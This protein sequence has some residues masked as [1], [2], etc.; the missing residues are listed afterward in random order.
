MSFFP[1]TSS[2]LK[3][4]ITSEPSGC[5]AAPDVMES[6][7]ELYKVSID[8]VLKKAQGQETATQWRL[9]EAG[10][11]DKY[12]QTNHLEYAALSNEDAILGSDPT[13]SKN[14]IA[15]P[16]RKTVK[17][18]LDDLNLQSPTAM[19]EFFDGYFSAFKSDEKYTTN[20]TLADLIEGR[21]EIDLQMA[22]RLCVL[23]MENIIAKGIPADLAQE[24]K[25]SAAALLTSGCLSDARN[26]QA[27]FESLFSIERVSRV[28][29]VE[30][31]ARL[32]GGC[33]AGFSISSGFGVEHMTSES[34]SRSFSF[35]P[36]SAALSWVI[37]VNTGLSF[38]FTKT[39]N[40][41]Q[42]NK[43]DS[44]F[45][46]NTPFILE[47]WELE[48]TATSHESCAVIRVAPEFWEKRSA[49]MKKLKNRATSANDR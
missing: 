43:E 30:P 45:S 3:L 49:T 27:G 31:T 1:R 25:A 41:V 12:L 10:A 28:F 42:A 26:A 35:D 6:L 36:L 18:V 19:K 4:R 5:K 40:E 44:F 20:Q 39:W 48:L 17:S 24:G 33:Q 46:V 38:A 11:L 7:H 2:I 14:N 29:E 22:G 8:D 32:A 47:K 13:L 37:P 34:Q 23:M 16:N 9:T 15:L 21:R